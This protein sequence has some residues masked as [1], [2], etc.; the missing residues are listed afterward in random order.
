MEGRVIETDVP[1]KLYAL[2]LRKLSEISR[3]SE[4]ELVDGMYN[5]DDAV[6]MQG[7]IVNRG[8][9]VPFEA[10]GKSP[11]ASFIDSTPAVTQ[12][13]VTAASST[14]CLEGSDTPKCLLVLGEYTVIEYILA[15]LYVAGMEKIVILISYFGCEIMQT[16]KN[17]FLYPKM[18]ITFLNLGDETPYGHA[19]ALLSAREM[20]STPFLIHTADHIFDKTILYRL[21][22]FQLQ[23]SVACV[24]ADSGIIGTP[25]LPE[26]AGK[27]QFGVDG[28]VRRIGRNLKQYDAI[29]AGLFLVTDRIFAALELLAYQK[30]KFSLAEALN[31]LRPRFGLKYMDVLGEGWLSVETEKQL[32]R[33]IENDTILSLSPWPV[34]VA[35]DITVEEGSQD[36]GK[37][38]FMAVSAT[39]D[40][41]SLR[42]VDARD[43]STIF[44]GFV[45]GV[46]QLEGEYAEEDMTENTPLLKP[47]VSPKLSSASR[48][49]SSSRLVRK[50][51]SYL[52]TSEEPFVLSIPVQARTHQAPTIL[53]I[54][55]FSNN[56]ERNAYIIELPKSPTS[57]SVTQQYIL[58]VSG[59]NGSSLKK[60][61]LLRQ[62]SSLPTDVKN[63]AI[64]AT[65]LQDG[66]LQVQVLVER[67]VPAI[68]YILLVLSL[69]AISSMGVAFNLQRDVDPFLKLFWRSSAS[70]LVLVPLSGASILQNGFPRVTSR[71]LSLFLISSVSH[72]LF[73]MTFLWALNHTSISHAY[74]F[75]NCHSLLL[76]L[77]RV[78]L[79][80]EVS[81]HEFAGTG[82]GIV[83]GVL[84]AF[85][86]SSVQDSNIVGVSAFGDFVALVGAIGGALY[87]TSVKEIRRDVDVPVLIT[88]IFGLTTLLHFPV[89][90]LLKIPYTFSTDIEI[91]LFGWAGSPHGA[92]IELYIVLICTIVGTL[93]YVGV[94]KYFDPIVI[95][96]VMLAEPILACLFGVVLNVEAIPG[97]CTIAGAL[98]I[99][100]GTFLVVKKNGSSTEV[101]NATDAMSA[102][103][104]GFDFPPTISASKK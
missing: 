4:R 101:I 95:S 15:Q 54:E 55:T 32:E 16:I 18:N 60:P 17:S 93:G 11:D 67:Q 13:L 24:L 91:G 47:L 30:P 39:D 62:L 66:R 99:L 75:N 88:A 19:R 9:Q 85:D 73:L 31:V 38:V 100:F 52:E 50:R 1:S 14:M 86:Q 71:L 25:G 63:V 21:A 58:A 10:I 3:L 103:T 2:N 64:G 23:G 104:K 36:T 68:G 69:F 77:G 96:I 6:D 81:K 59:G 89:F 87:L 90:A 98:L 82:V 8:D 43:T 49:Q 7:V 29:D 27:V 57:P 37:S 72:A 74:I 5:A 22:S 35:K 44:E 26:T 94:L 45:V 41:S 65:E 28:N 83:G 46:D 97:L 102:S 40:D 48:R 12:V 33:A 92:L 53:Q 79:A 20:F 51:S 70:L 61:T 84:A 34:F 80:N 56:A 78:L 76:V 42:L